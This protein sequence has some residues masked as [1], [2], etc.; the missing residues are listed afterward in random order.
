MGKPP[1]ALQVVATA[2]LVMIFVPTAIHPFTGY[3][4][5]VPKSEIRPLS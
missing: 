4:A 2:D 3:L 5:F 1:A